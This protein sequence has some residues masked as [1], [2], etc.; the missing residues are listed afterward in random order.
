MATH[1][2]I[3]AWRIPW[4]EEPAGYSPW[5][6][7]SQTW[8]RVMVTECDTWHID[9]HYQRYQAGCLKCRIWGS[10]ADLTEWESLGKGSK[11]VFL[12]TLF[13]FFHKFFFSVALGLYCWAWSFSSC[14]EWG[15]LFVA[16]HGFL[17]AVASL[18]V[19][20]RLLGAQAS[21]VAATGLVTVAQR[22]LAV[23]QGVQSTGSVALQHVESFWTRDW[24][25]V[26]CIGR[27]ILIHCTPR[28]VPRLCLNKLSRW[29]L[30]MGK[31]ETY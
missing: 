15:L 27:L 19:E 28:E 24:T 26:P 5:G 6:C 13:I 3:L 10:I 9:R 20:H 11:T 23:A 18:V 31:F 17:T 16:V 8:P 14:C 2:S 25:H 21:A 22:L 29:C 12:N 7:K 30:S 4:T 1:S